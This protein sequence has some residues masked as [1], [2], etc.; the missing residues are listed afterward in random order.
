[1]LDIFQNS[2]EEK[3]GEY[4]IK[5]SVSVGYPSNIW[6]YEVFHEGKEIA[7]LD[8]SGP[9]NENIRVQSVIVEEKYQGLY[10]ATKLY[11]LLEADLFNAGLN[12][13]PSDIRTPDA[14][15]F[16]EDRIR[17]KTKSSLIKKSKEIENDST[18]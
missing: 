9:F 14:I 8:F 12:L 10:I 1:M 13:M 6:L 18:D 11:D 4:L 3:H 2:L 16:W 15:E 5:R 17:K 7:F